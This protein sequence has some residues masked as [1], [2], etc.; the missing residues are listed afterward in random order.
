MRAIYITIFFLIIS[1]LTIAQFLQKPL[2]KTKPFRT[3]IA[4]N[5]NLSVETQIGSSRFSF[6][7]ELTYL[8]RLRTSAFW[9]RSPLFYWTNGIQTITGCRFY[10]DRNLKYP[11]G[12]FFSL[13]AG[14]TYT[15]TKRQD[16]FSDPGYLYTAN[17]TTKYPEINLAIGKQILVYNRLSIDFLLGI[18]T[19]FCHQRKL[20]ILMSYDN[21]DLIGTDIIESYGASSSIFCRF[22]IGLLLIKNK[23]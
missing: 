15:Y 4:W 6:N 11:R 19:I 16:H 22:S 17:T 7:Q 18:N 1:N 23:T 9:T 8:L 3:A 14:Y 21:R 10:F 5:P 13:Q 2:L 20:H 12:H